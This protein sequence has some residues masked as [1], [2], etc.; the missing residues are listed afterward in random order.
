[1]N[2]KKLK[3]LIKCAS[4]DIHRGA[5][6]VVNFKEK[7]AQ[8]SNGFILLQMPLNEEPYTDVK[9]VPIE[10]IIRE[11]DEVLFNTDELES[12]DVKVFYK[13]PDVN[14]PD[15]SKIVNQ[16]VP[17]AEAIV[18][19]KLL[20][21]MITA[22]K[23]ADADKVKIKMYGNLKAIEFDI[24]LPYNERGRGFIMPMRGIDWE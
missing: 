14:F 8:A 18:D 11:K 3:A 10:K 21:T 22:L 4:K 15:V 20:E 23:A 19:V 9:N 13:Q 2:Y 24:K 17:L 7:I 12:N 6:R 5:L 1:M 16:G